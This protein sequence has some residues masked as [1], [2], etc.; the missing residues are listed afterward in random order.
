MLLGR[1]H[2]IEPPPGRNPGQLGHKAL[3]GGEV[4]QDLRLV[5]GLVGG[6]FEVVPADGRVQ[7]L[8]ELTPMWGQVE[9][10]SSSLL[11]LLEP[12]AAIPWPVRCVVGQGGQQHHPPE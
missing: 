4:G 10:P 5:A 6:L 1:F 8:E 11:Q 9:E 2:P 3:A 7:G 12:L